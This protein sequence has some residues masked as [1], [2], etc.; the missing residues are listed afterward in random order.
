MLCCASGRRTV[1]SLL[2]RHGVSAPVHRYLNEFKQQLS[3]QLCVGRPR[4][5]IRLLPGSF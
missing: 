1:I 5:V 3:R 2:S 4:I